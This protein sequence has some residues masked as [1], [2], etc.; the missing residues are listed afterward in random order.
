[1]TTVLCSE[2]KGI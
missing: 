2:G 1:M